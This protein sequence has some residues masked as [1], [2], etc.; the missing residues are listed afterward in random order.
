MCVYVRKKIN[1]F[2]VVYACLIMT[3]SLKNKLVA[4]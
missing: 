1:K 2:A 3:L 4:L